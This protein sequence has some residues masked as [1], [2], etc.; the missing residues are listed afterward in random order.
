MTFEILI[1]VRNPTDVLRQTVE[2]LAAQTGKNFSVL[3]SDNFSTTG[4]EHIEDALAVLARAQVSSRRIRPPS[5]LGR[6]EHWNW[7]HYQSTADWLKPLFAGDWLEPDYVASVSGVAARES[8]CVYIFC[9]YQYHRGGEIQGGPLGLRIDRFLTPPEMQE[10]VL[11]NGM[12]FGPPSVSAYR[13]DAFLRSGGYDP[14]LPICADSLFFCKLAA[15]HGAYGLS[16][17]GAHFFIHAARFSDQLPGKQR[18]LLRETMRYLV[19][20]GATAW[21]ERWRFPVFGYL[22]LLVRERRQRRPAR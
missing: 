19:E 9:N 1:P 15:R 17:V 2:S 10:E 8:Q 16:R 21:H 22:R 13:R 7:L 6:V 18:E 3:I 20:L 11:R 12:Q 14:T 4:Q 5:E